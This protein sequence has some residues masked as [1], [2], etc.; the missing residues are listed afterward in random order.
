[1]PR[2]VAFKD[3][4]KWQWRVLV[5]SQLHLRGNSGIQAISEVTLGSNRQACAFYVDGKVCNKLLNIS[6]IIQEQEAKIESIKTKFVHITMMYLLWKSPWLV[7]LSGNHRPFTVH[8]DF[9]FNF[10]ISVLAHLAICPSPGLTVSGRLET[11]LSACHPST[12]TLFYTSISIVW[13]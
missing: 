9:L 4:F 3:T 2:R 6:S 12:L 5:G 1:M 7:G 13:T 10:S 11:Q 8:W